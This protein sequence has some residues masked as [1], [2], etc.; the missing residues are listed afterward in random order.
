[1]QSHKTKTPDRVWAWGKSVGTFLTVRVVKRH[2]LT[3]GN[4]STCSPNCT[5]KK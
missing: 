1:M 4:V 5:F 2:F 3:S